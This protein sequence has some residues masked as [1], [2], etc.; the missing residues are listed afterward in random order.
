M[1]A[2]RLGLSARE[3]ISN[4]PPAK[5]SSFL[6]NTLVV[7]G[8]AGFSSVVFFKFEVISCWI[9]HSGDLC[10]STSSAA[11]WLSVYV[12]ELTTIAIISAPTAETSSPI[13]KERVAILAINRRETLE[14]FCFTVA[15]CCALIL[16]S[17]LG[18]ASAN[19]T[20]NTFTGM[21]GMVALFVV[22]WLR[23]SDL[24][25]TDLQGGG[26]KNTV[27]DSRRFSSGVFGGLV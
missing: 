26:Q 17:T 15:G 9:E 19:Y 24:R 13:T 18:V 16:L 27:E 21:A 7:R 8:T 20:T 12:L 10:N 3:R 14:G 22:T 4:L 11:I 6:V 23:I 5:L 2:F 25:R 1:V